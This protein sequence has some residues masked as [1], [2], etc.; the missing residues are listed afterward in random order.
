[1]FFKKRESAHKN[2]IYLLFTY[3]IDANIIETYCPN[4]LYMFF[5]YIAHTILHKVI[6]VSQ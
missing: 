3:I 1:M 5:Y 4:I 2:R 6:E